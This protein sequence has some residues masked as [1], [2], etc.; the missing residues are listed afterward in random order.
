MR[1]SVLFAAG[2]F[3]LQVSG[4]CRATKEYAFDATDFHAISEVSSDDV[5]PLRLLKTSE[6]DPGTWVTEEEK[7]KNYM[8]KHV[9]FMDVTETEV[10]PTPMCSC[11]FY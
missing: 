1:T 6:D 2:A 5:E 3:L 11:Y 4:A 7:I 9:H 10:G 8:L